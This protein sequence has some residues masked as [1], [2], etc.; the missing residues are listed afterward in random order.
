M[1]DTRTEGV[2]AVASRCGSEEERR[3]EGRRPAGA[4][5]PP[6]HLA[7]AHGAHGARRDT[8]RSRAT[9]IGGSVG[10]VLGRGNL[11]CHLFSLVARCSIDRCVDQY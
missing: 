7:H 1:G 6:S 5:P 2:G 9:G 11:K 3:Q 8:P 4:A 10:S